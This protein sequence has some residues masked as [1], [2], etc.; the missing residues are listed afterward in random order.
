LEKVDPNSF[1]LIKQKSFTLVI[2][3]LNEYNENSVVNLD[4]SECEKKLRENLPS[5]TILKIVQINIPQNNNEIDFSECNDIPIIVE[6]TKAD[7]S[8]LNMV[9]ILE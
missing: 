3:K 7:I 9:K 4:F 6:N 8:Q 5:D 1:Y 2:N